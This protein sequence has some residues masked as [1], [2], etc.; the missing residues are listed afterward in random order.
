MKKPSRASLYRKTKNLAKRLKLDDKEAYYKS[1]YRRS[2]SK[3]WHDELK[4]LKKLS[5]TRLLRK[6]LLEKKLF[7]YTVSESK[8]RRG[9]LSVT[10]LTHTIPYHLSIIKENLPRIKKE[11]LYVISKHTRTRTRSKRYDPDTL[12]SISV[13]STTN[14]TISTSFKNE[15]D[16]NKFMQHQ[17][18]F[19]ASFYQPEEF[20]ID[21]IEF[22]YA[23]SSIMR[24]YSRSMVVANEKWHVARLVN[25]WLL[26][27]PHAKT[28]Q[29]CWTHRCRASSTIVNGAS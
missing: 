20:I 13:I 22:S 23:Y 9:T 21:K 2:T 5:L 26:L 10:R 15:I 8:M 29:T 17:L 6:N 7:D 16:L 1:L 19:K 24:G 3:T 18:G 28:K 12:F 14:K 27:R 4:V 25:V 11:L